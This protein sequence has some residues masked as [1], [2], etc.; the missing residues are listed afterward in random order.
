MKT[1]PVP[2]T[3]HPDSAMAGSPEPVSPI[4]AEWTSTMKGATGPAGVVLA[5]VNGDAPSVSPKQI[6]RA[7]REDLEDQLL[8]DGATRAL[9]AG[10]RVLQEEPDPYRTCFE[11]DRDRILHASAFRRLAGKTQ[12]FVFPEDH[13]RTRL[14]H[15][16]EV[17]QFAMSISRALVLNVALT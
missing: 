14:T 9:G 10:D 13:Q 6:T 3:D 7:Q 16:I 12:V 8:A 15:A 5:H 4:Q 2:Q 11:R 1:V 17:A